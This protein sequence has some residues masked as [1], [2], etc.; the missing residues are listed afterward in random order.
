MELIHG[1]DWAS[2]QAQYHRMPLDFS[3]NISPLGTP[4]GVRRAIENAVVDRYP[5]PLC[6]SLRAALAQK[7]AL[8]AEYILCGNGA[9]ELIFRA[10]L[11]R[12]P[13]RALL[14]VPTFSEYET[15]LQAAGCQVI[16]HALHGENDFALDEGILEA[17]QPGVDMVFLC[18]PNNPTGLAAPRSLMGKVLRCCRDAGALLVTDESFIDFLDDPGM[19]SLAGK[20]EKY[21]NLLILKSF[22]KLYAIPG[23]RLGYCL[24]SNTALLGAMAEAGPAWSVSSIAQEAGLAALCE[25]IYVFEVRKLIQKECPWLTEQLERLGL[26]VIPGQANYLMFQCLT[27]LTEPLG[28][29]GILLR[30]CGNYRGLDDTWY[31]TAVRTRE[32]NERLIRALEEV[33]AHG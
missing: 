6:R 19:H 8:P 20:V 3:A 18:Q 2:F 12:R 1:G 25:P 21:K 13:R 27:P 16:Y 14:T 26:R 33:L 10:V 22:T 32:D 4:D 15:A 11:A 31:R 24:S 5:D 17:I 29:R 23:V 30:S 9:A 7:E 28:Q